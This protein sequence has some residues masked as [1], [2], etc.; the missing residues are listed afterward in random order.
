[1]ARHYHPRMLL[2][3]LRHGTTL[4]VVSLLT[5]GLARAEEPPAELEYREG[6]PIPAG[7]R[8][9]ERISRGLVI[10][11]AS[12]FGAVYLANVVMVAY[13]GLGG[14]DPGP[15]PKWLYVPFAGPF[16][17]IAE[18]EELPAEVGVLLAVDGLAQV[19]GLATFIAGLATKEKVLVRDDSAT[20]T[21]IEVRP[22]F[23][24]GAAGAHLRF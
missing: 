11:G 19:G 16:V 7:Y 17:A 23:G 12:V 13:A 10:A 18:F 4:V 8:T 2:T 9:E 24:P 5:S 1:V 3:F 6:Q 21:R 20:G 14:I 22:I 15:G